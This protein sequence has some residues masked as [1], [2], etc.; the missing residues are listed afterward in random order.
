MTLAPWPDVVPSLYDP[1]P[2]HSGRG[3]TTPTGA[4][5]SCRQVPEHGTHAETRPASA[6]R[7]ATFEGRLIG[8]RIMRPLVVQ[9]WC[10]DGTSK[11]GQ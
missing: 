11:S 6:H 10:E 8:S 9:M 2:L 5:P 4:A 1:R 7:V 3:G